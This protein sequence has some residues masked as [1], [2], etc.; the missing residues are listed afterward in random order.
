[1][2]NQDLRETTETAIWSCELLAS[3]L[4]KHG[5]K[6]S[7][8]DCCATNAIFSKKKCTI[9]YHARGLKVPHAKLEVAESV[10]KTL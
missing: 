10:L 4:T 3:A 9:A 5:F 8:C 1:M 7:P 2:L 6:L